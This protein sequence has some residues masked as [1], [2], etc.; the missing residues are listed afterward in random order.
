MRAT[1]IAGRR[2]LERRLRA[3]YARERRGE[4][5]ADE[6]GL[7]AALSAA[8]EGAPRERAGLAAL[9]AAQ[10]R[11]MSRTAL[12]APLL[13]VALVALA[14]GLGA[15]RTEALVTL[16]FSGAALTAACLHQL[17]ASSACGMVELEAA[18]PLNAH[19]AGCARLLVMGCLSAAALLACV[20]ACA[21]LADV[22]ELAARACAPYLVSSA[23]G[24]LVARR[25]PSSGAQAATLVWSAF[26]CAAC[27][28]LFTVAPTAYATASA[29]AWYAAALLGAAWYAREAALWLRRLSQPLEVPE[30][31]FEA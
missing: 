10:L 18:C 23:G 22:G 2:D 30:P 4:A 27:V 7:L 1:D 8:A 31:A 11:F 13:C 15:T 9:V 6:D 3:H 14:C 5:P 20:A 24:L 25:C 26:A 16:S 19:A 12:A 21:P 17:T 28:L 29:G